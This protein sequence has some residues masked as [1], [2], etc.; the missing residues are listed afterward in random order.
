MVANQRGCL[1]QWVIQLWGTHVVFEKMPT[2]SRRYHGVFEIK[3]CH[4]KNE[5]CGRDK[6]EKIA[7][8]RAIAEICQHDGQGRLQHN[9]DARDKADYD[10][11]DSHKQ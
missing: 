6:L 5:K 7:K 4:A 2:F 9:H 10:T 8:C 1:H 3:Q 11:G